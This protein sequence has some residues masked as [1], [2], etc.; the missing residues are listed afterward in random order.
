MATPAQGSP[1]KGGMTVW[2]VA[3]MGA[4]LAVTAGF[5]LPRLVATGAL[6]RKT[7]SK[8]TPVKETADQPDLDCAPS[9]QVGDRA[10]NHSP[11]RERG[12]VVCPPSLARRAKTGPRAIQ[13]ERIAKASYQPLPVKEAAAKPLS[14]KEAG[15]IP[16]L[17]KETPSKAA[18]GKETASKPRPPKKQTDLAYSLP[19]WPDPPDSDAMIFRLAI[20][21]VAV[22]FL[23]VGTL[24][25]GK[26]CLGGF[27]AKNPAVSH[28]R[29]VET[30]PLG[31]RGSLILVKA[32]T[33]KI[34]V[35]MDHAGI[36]GM[37]TLP[38]PFER[39]L[40]EIKSAGPLASEA[41]L[42]R[43]LFA[44]AGELEG[45]SHA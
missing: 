29:V 21:T 25:I 20:G 8:S 40:E 27:K 23:S 1:S 9:A 15:A 18:P 4:L 2:L 17:A 12:P 45:R 6:F 39:A 35:G 3:G 5:L 31:R 13:A 22:L 19:A 26:R 38:Q 28:L 10:L 43:P 14:L 24:W 36:K 32:G 34:L 11:T 16:I 37:L 30:L 33:Q 41:D 44:A 42:E 7:A